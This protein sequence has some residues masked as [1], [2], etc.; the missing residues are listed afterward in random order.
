LTELLCRII[1]LVRGLLDKILKSAN[2][3]RF[4]LVGGTGIQSRDGYFST[5]DGVRLF[6]REWHTGNTVCYL[7][8]VHGLGE[9]SGRYN[10]LAEDFLREGVSSI[11]FDLR[12]HGKSE[13]K[14]GHIM[15]FNEYIY[16]LDNFK[17]MLLKRINKPLFLL[18]HSMGGLIAMSYAIKNSQG[19]SGL[20][21]SSPLFKI[22]VKVPAWKAFIGRTVSRLIPALSMNNELNANMLSH[23]TDVVK[24]Y[25]GDPL[26]HA[27]VSSRWFT[28]V[29]QTMEDTLNIADRLNIPILMLHAGADRL[30]DPVGSKEIFGRLRVESKALKIY[31]GFYH[32]IYNE[33]NR[34]EPI[35]DTIEWLRKR[36]ATLSAD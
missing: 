11:A 28:E 29:T 19:L 5:F 31:D 20:I 6:Y 15:N 9:H 22:R 16:D 18:G 27:K 26:V 10:Q 32:E 25:L 21:T 2:L 12:G 3:I 7:L 35:R 23:N 14:R 13:G 4:P 33:V 1:L 36:L 34:E 30:A 8:I 24:A 17:E